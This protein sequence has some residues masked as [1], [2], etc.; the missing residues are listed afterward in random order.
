MH[1]R[2]GILTGYLAK[3]PLVDEARA[4]WLRSYADEHGLDL[5]AS[6]GYG[7]SHADLVWLELLGNPTAVNPDTQLVRARR[8]EEA[9]E[10]RQVETRQPLTEA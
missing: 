3:P 1:D 9:L 4:A 6:Y 8:N 5:A 7:D 2:D 10:D